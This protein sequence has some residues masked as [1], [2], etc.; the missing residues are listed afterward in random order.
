MDRRTFFSALAATSGLACAGLGCG[1][2]QQP[3]APAAP[4][5]RRRLGRTGVDVTALA[6]GGVAGMKEA[7][8]AKFDPAAL[9][10]AALDAGITYFDTAAAYNN[11][12]SERNYG[13]V[14]ARRRN[15][16]FLATKTGQRTYD[17]ALRDL[18]ASLKRLRTDRV[19]LIQIHGANAS[20]DPARWGKPDGVLKALEKLREQKVTR[21]IGVTGHDSAEVMAQAITMYDFDTVLTTFN[22]TPRRRP[23]LEKV[24]PMAVKKQMGILA[25]KVMGG[26]L[27]SL[28]AGNPAKNDGLSSHDEALH[29][30]DA[31]ALIRYALGLPI[32]VAIVGMSSLAQLRANRRAAAELAPLSADK[33]KSL[34]LRMSS[35]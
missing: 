8:S 14:L 24:L 2:E 11:G 35:P 17:G 20:D 32:T 5:P 12:Q 21:F 31:D 26:G 6:L 9:A 23:F 15:E 33:R 30:A 29:Q 18:E 1:A 25:M 10:N 16:V 22:P 7:P 4:L 3:K 28:A 34:E 19:D 27:G 13:E